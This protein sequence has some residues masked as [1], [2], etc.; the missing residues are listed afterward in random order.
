VIFGPSLKTTDGWGPLS[1]REDEGPR[2]RF[3]F[4]PG[5]AVDLIWSWAEW[6]P[7]AR[8][9]FFYFLFFFSFSDFLIS[10]LEF[11]Y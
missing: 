10:F 3:G 6:G 8:F 1:V 9:Q 2:Y 11:A 7:Q 5:W 4:L